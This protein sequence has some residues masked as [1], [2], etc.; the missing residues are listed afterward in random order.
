MRTL[1]KYDTLCVGGVDVF[2][3]MEVKLD[4][5]AE[6]ARIDRAEQLIHFHSIH[7]TI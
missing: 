6:W 4:A 1:H 3:T 7:F 5:S 2:E